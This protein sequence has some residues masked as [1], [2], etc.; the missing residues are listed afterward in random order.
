[1]NDILKCNRHVSECPRFNT[2]HTGHTPS[3]ITNTFAKVL[4]LFIYFHVSSWHKIRSVPIYF[5]IH[6]GQTHSYRAISYVS[7]LCN[8]RHLHARAVSLFQDFAIFPRSITGG[9]RADKYTFADPLNASWNRLR[10]HFFSLASILLILVHCTSSLS[11]Y[12]FAYLSGQLLIS[13]PIDVSVCLS[14][15]VYLFI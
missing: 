3:F 9:Q 14:T 1:M 7:R 13:V 15:Y 10:K 6:L 4:K 8:S 12:L 2:G 5:H 11:L